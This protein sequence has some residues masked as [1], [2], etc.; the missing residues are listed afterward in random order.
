MQRVCHSQCM[1]VFWLANFAN[2][3]MY[4]TRCINYTRSTVTFTELIDTES[5]AYCMENLEDVH[6]HSYDSIVNANAPKCMCDLGRVRL[7]KRE[8]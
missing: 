6:S 5:H 1:G 2:L 8:C 4:C 3:Y 7:S